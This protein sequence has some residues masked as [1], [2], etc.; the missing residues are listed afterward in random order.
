MAGTEDL[1]DTEIVHAIAPGAALDVDLVPANAA[2]ATS[3]DVQ[4]ASSQVKATSGDAWLRQAA[5]WS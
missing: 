5:G 3:D 2:A 1:E 4:Q